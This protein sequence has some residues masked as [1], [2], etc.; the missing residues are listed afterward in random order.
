MTC[1]L[2]HRLVQTHVVMTRV[3]YYTIMGTGV[4]FIRYKQCLICFERVRVES[5]LK[6]KRDAK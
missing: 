3:K 4:Q 5:E 2:Q 1:S 6:S